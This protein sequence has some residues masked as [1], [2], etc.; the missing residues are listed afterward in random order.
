[1]SLRQSLSPA[2]VCPEGGWEQSAPR[3]HIMPAVSK[4]G[5]TKGGDATGHPG[6]FCNT[7]KRKCVAAP[8]GPAFPPRPSGPVTSPRAH[9]GTG[10]TAQRGQSGRGAAGL[11]LHA[12][13]V[14]PL[15]TGRVPSAPQS[16]SAFSRACCVPCPAASSRGTL[17]PHSC[18]ALKPI[19]EAASGSAF[20]TKL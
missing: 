16:S 1:M 12:S 9:L 15:R 18:S 20:K 13:S 14:Q 2:C 7:S 8:P 19:S 11:P 5:C 3:P 10:T 6:T 4:L 17:L